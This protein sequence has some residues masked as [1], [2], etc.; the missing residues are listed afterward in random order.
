MLFEA[1]KIVCFI[2]QFLKGCSKVP[3]KASVHGICNVVLRIWNPILKS[4]AVNLV[5]NEV[6]HGI[7][8]YMLLLLS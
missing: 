1:G 3:Q 8:A 2:G 6:Q 4:F 5:Y 7:F